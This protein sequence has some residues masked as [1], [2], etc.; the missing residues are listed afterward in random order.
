MRVVTEQGVPG[1]VVRIVHEAGAQNE[2][3]G[4]RCPRCL[5]WETVSLDKVDLT[6]NMCYRCRGCGHIFS[7]RV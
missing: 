1:E 3:A 7:P 2:A 5:A 4:K 6:G